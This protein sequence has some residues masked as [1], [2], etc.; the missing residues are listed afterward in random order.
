VITCQD[1]G[2]PAELVRDGGNGFVVTA[3]PE[4]MARA[5]RTVVS[6]RTTAIRLGEAGAADVARMTWPDAVAKLLI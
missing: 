3:T 6:D 4:A 5:L 1:S 2:G